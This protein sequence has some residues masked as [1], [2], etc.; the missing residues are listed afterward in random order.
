MMQTY[1]GI[2]YPHLSVNLMFWGEVKDVKRLPKT[3]SFVWFLVLIP[4]T[5]ANQSSLIKNFHSADLF[6]CNLLNT[7]D[8]NKHSFNT[9]RE[10]NHYQSRNASALAIP[11][12]RTTRPE[13]YD[14][15]KI[16]N[17]VKSEIEQIHIK[18]QCWTRMIF[19]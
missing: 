8:D 5:V 19:F 6:Q 11:R 17:Y 1:Y 12:H 9:N 13:N 7:C 10:Y 15:M 3:K 4:E 16:F 2:L 14:S 18:N